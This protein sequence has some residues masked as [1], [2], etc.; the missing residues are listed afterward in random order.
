MSPIAV[1]DFIPRRVL[2]ARES[3]DAAAPAFIRSIAEDDSPITLDFAGLG[4]VSPSAVDQLL[5]RIEEAFTGRDV[6][7]SNMPFPQEGVHEAIARAHGRTLIESGP[8][9]WTFA[10]R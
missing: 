6:H 3:V 2:I 4:A 5:V 10:A 8:N 1:A 7:F 9:S